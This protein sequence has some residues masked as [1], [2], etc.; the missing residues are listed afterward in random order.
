MQICLAGYGTDFDRIARGK[1]RG[2]LHQTINTWRN[3]IN[4]ENK[5][6]LG[7]SSLD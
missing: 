6:G 4:K 1:G 7:V 2:L 3:T 5:L